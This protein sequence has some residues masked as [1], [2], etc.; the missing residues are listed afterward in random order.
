MIFIKTDN[1]ISTLQRLGAA[2]SDPQ[3]RIV[4]SRAINKTLGQGRTIARTEVKK[5]YNISQKDLDG[6]DF[7]RANPSNVTGSLTASRK[8]IPLDS[9]GP[10]Q[11]TGSGSV[12]ITKRGAHKTI[13]FKRAKANPTAGV[14]I[15]VFKGKRE[16]IPYAF[17]L[18]GGAARVFARGQY[19]SGTQYGFGAPSP[20]QQ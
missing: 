15:E 4:I 6:I 7:K 1:A 13:T 14:S 3:L 9:F 2:L 12:R 19:R 20:R 10:R 5:V 16:V 8:P 17:L 11:E 18:T